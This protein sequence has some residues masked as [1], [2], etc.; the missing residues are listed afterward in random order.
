MTYSNELQRKALEQDKKF[1]DLDLE[2]QKLQELVAKMSNEMSSLKLDKAKAESDV[3]EWKKAFS[4]AAKIAVKRFKG[5]KEYKDEIACEVESVVDIFYSGGW[6]DSVDHTLR[7]Y[8]ELD[9]A[10]LKDPKKVETPPAEEEGSDAPVNRTVEAAEDEEMIDTMTTLE[11]GADT[12][13]L[14]GSG[15]KA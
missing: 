5:S 15:D 9:R 12:E 10:R 1:F 6:N 3:V 11:V 4:D 7:E 2:N 14:D 13:G 8:P